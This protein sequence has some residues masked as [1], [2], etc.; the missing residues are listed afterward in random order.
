[1]LI[2]QLV[3]HGERHLQTRLETRLLNLQI[4]IHVL[5]L[6][7][8]GHDLRRPLQVL[9]EKGRQ[10][11]HQLRG[12]IAVAA[13][14]RFKRIEGVEQ[15]MRIDLGM[16]QLNLRLRQ[17]GFLPLILPG[18]DLRGQQLGDPLPSVRLME[19]NRRFFASY[20]LMVPITR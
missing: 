20:S 5:N 10:K 17:Q 8:E 2:R 6:I 14:H 19:L 3:R 18:E 16:Q 15:E 12:L 9:A 1:M 4:G 13:D 11:L 7:G